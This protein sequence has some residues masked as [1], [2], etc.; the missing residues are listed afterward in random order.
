VKED[1][2]DEVDLRNLR[3]KMGTVMEKIEKA[4]KHK[5]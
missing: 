4:P 2:F 5:E 3:E 1:W